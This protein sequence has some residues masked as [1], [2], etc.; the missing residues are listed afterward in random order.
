[1]GTLAWNYRGLGNP[2]TFQVLWDLVQLRKPIVISLM[3]TMI[4]QD[5]METIRAKMNYE[6]FLTV[7]GSGHGGGLAMFW[8]LKNIISIK[9]YSQNHINTEI[10]L[11]NVNKW[12]MTCF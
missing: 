2:N 12:R 3:E 7:A 8:K 6:G 1:M 9:S 10:N 4:D 11:K 5:I